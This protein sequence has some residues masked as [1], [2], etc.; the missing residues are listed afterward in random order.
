MNAARLLRAVRLILAF[1]VAVSFLIPVVWMLFVSVKT[2]GTPIKTLIDW[3]RPPYTFVNYVSVL[4][5]TPMLR[6][7]GNSLFIALVKTV[8]TVLF[9]SLAAFA[10]SKIRFAYKNAIL[11]FFIAGLMIPGKRR[12]FLCMR[13]SRR[14]TYWTATWASFC[15]GLPRRSGLLF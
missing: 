2:E 12:S 9:T 8:L 10:I 6:W 11:L 3:F 5:K 14:W 4:S 15:L 13:W 7:M 1:A